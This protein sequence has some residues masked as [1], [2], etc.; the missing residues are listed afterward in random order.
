MTAAS[1]AGVALFIFTGKGMRGPAIAD[2]LV[3]ALPAMAKLL[4]CSGARS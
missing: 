1:T 3:Q 4:D 2:A